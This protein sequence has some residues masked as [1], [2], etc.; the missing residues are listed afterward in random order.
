M[1]TQ[2]L[3]DF[4]VLP[5]YDIA[6]HMAAETQKP[7]TTWLYRII[8]DRLIVCYQH[9]SGYG[10]NSAIS[11]MRKIETSLLPSE[12]D[13]TI[14]LISV[15]RLHHHEEPKRLKISLKEQLA[16]VTISRSCFRTWCEAS[17]YALP[18]FWFGEG[19]SSTATQPPHKVTDRNHAD[20]NNLPPKTRTDALKAL[21]LKLVEE[22]C[23]TDVESVWLALGEKAGRDSCIICCSQGEKGPEVLWQSADGKQ[24]HLNKKA[25]GGRL[26]SYRRAGLIP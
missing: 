26:K 8:K 6:K 24:N 16:N 23:K 5:L 2:D 4:E 9:E 7:L 11:C 15:G 13:Y 12:E 17:G 19:E 21:I 14:K 1:V 25:L 22:G 10:V 3:S 18:R 20:G